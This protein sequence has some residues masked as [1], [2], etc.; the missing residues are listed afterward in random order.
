M[1]VVG[2]GESMNQASRNTTVLK[3]KGG[4][5]HTDVCFFIP[6]MFNNHYH[7][8]HI[9]IYSKDV[10]FSDYTGKQLDMWH[11]LYTCED[12]C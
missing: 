1:G 6:I 8:Q 12:T 2:A 5:W 4:S 11:T 3:G 10:E 9:C 7:T